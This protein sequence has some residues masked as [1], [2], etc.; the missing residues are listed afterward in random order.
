MWKLG[1]A[2]I[3]EYISKKISYDCQPMFYQLAL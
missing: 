1:P 2:K 3:Y